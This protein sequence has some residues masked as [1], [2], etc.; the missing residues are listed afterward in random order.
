MEKTGMIKHIKFLGIP[1]SNQD[2]AIEFYTK[3]LGFELVTDQPFNEQQR[4]IELK[5][6]G[7]QTGI[8]LFTPDEHQARIG[9]FVN[10]AIACDNVERTYRELQEKGVECLGAPKKEHWGSFFLIKDSDGNTLCLAS[11]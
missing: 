7:A 1:V 6:P 5:I 8:S 10:T 9:T 2:R 3:K 4:W 11:S